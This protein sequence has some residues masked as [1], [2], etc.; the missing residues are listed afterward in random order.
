MLLENIGKGPCIKLI[1]IINF[2]WRNNISVS[3][4]QVSLLIL[5]TS[6][7]TIANADQEDYEKCLLRE[8]QN[9]TGDMSVNELKDACTP[10]TLP[11]MVLFLSR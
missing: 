3:I 4:R 8:I 6:V 10:E 1:G 7:S 2:A 5:V 11:S 9:A